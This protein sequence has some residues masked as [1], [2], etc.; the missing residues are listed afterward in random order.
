MHF[1]PREETIIPLLAL[2]NKQIGKRL[3]LNESTVEKCVSNIIIKFRAKTRTSAA[4]LAYYKGYNMEIP[5]YDRD[6]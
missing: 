3:G 1:T 2:I 5:E 6:Y 4:L